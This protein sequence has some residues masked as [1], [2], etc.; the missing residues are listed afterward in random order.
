MIFIA[1]LTILAIVLCCGCTSSN[2][3]ATKTERATTSAVQEP[4]RSI[5]KVQISSRELPS[6]VQQS[7]AKP[8]FS[9]VA[10][11]SRL[12]FT[13]DNGARGQVLMVESIGGG[14]GWL[15]YD[16]DGN[17]DAF[18]PQ[19][20]DPAP[21]LDSP[22]PR[23][24]L[25]R[26]ISPEVFVAVTILA[27]IDEQRYSMGVTIGDYDN[28]GFDDIY[29]T[30]VGRN[31]LFHN[32]GDGTFVDVTEQSGVGDPRW[33]SSAAWGDL[34]LDGDLDLYVC[35]Y[36]EYDTYHPVPCP[37]ENGSPGTCHPKDMTPVPDECFFNNGDGTFSAEARQRG[38]YGPGNKAL[39]VVIADLNQDGWP[40]VYI[41]NDTTPNFLFI[42]QRD[43]KFQE[44]AVL[45]GCA[46][47]REG[48]PQA[49]MGVGLGDFDRNGWLDL[50]C[51][52]FTFESNTLYK[53]LG[54]SGFQD[55]TGLV[56]LHTPTLTKLAFGTVMSDFNQDGHQ[57]IFVTNGHIDDW[58]YKGEDREMVGQL[59][60]YVGPRF[61]EATDEAGDYFKRRLIGRGVASCD[62]DQDGD[63]DLLVAHQGTPAALLR[64]DSERGHWLKL[65]FTGRQS[66]RHG[67]GTRVTIYQK[68]LK[69]FQELAG[70]TSYA[71]SHEKCLIVGLGSQKDPCQIE[72]R[73]PSGRTQVLDDVH[74][75]QA[76]HLT[77]PREA[78]HSR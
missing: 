62:Y 26:Q 13:Y 7:V 33:S 39:G 52:H 51:T 74:V 64:N 70:G 78:E 50:Y 21:L 27:G 53:C 48:L 3:E 58:K 60:C 56:G 49:S 69:F 72:I 34:D 32:Q 15:D 2:S 55:V 68:G 45:L 71:S 18:F 20:G 77:E 29:V 1:R 6:P 28:D 8:R 75:D 16:L 63:L 37:R 19:G 36:V 65:R 35:N 42:N 73:W 24:E 31:S 5:P 40:D 43:A 66:N 23:D 4:P 10:A 14:C 67:I 38:L 44:Q 9:D 11:T 54:E 17:A 47:S 30:N 22:Q 12:N 46:V 76:I 57:D 41:A 59:F 61:I 25:F